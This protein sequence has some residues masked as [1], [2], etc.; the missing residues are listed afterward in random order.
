M[1]MNIYIGKD[2][3]GNDIYINL[4]KENIH[5]ILLIGMTGSG[6]SIFHNNL[7]YQ[8]VKQNTPEEIG[9][10][11]LDMTHVDF[12]S[13]HS[14]YMLFPTI[15]NTEEAFI[16]LGKLGED[17]KRRAENIS[18]AIRSIVVQIEE[19]NMVAK[20]PER[21]EKA[22]FNILRAKE[23]NNMYL[24]FSTSRP[25]KDV[26][27][28]MML[29]HADLKV[30]FKVSSM[31]DSN[32]LLGNNRAVAFTKPG[33]RVLVYHHKQVVYQPFSSS[34]IERLRDMELKTISDLTVKFG[35]KYSPK[36][37]EFIELYKK[38]IQKKIPYYFALIKKEGIVPFS[39]Y[40]P[41]DFES[42]KKSIISD[43]KANKILPL[44]VYL[45]K[46]KFIMSDDY[47]LYY[48]YMELGWDKLPCY[49]MGEPIGEYV[50]EKSLIPGPKLNLEAR[51]I[52]NS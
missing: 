6:K 20:D 44:H 24:I 32:Y 38:V 34:E 15:V 13:W 21:F 48:A 45:K 51:L 33:E 1:N 22:L 4:E 19:C 37:K 25:S 9:F 47:I 17:S 36:D 30:V 10:A 50:I 52:N 8:L 42:I 7:Y 16:A 2:S 23:K 3:N 43:I 35:G 26:I 40:K 29:D 28:Q 46:G 39:D 49:V 12:K 18:S 14:P 31:Q 5:F 27:T 11:F 41:T